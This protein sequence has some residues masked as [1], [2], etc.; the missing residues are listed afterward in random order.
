MQNRS[1]TQKKIVVSRRQFNRSTPPSNYHQ[2]A[3]HA[4]MVC[5]II[6]AIEDLYIR[7]KIAPCVGEVRRNRACAK[8]DL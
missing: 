3:K 4:N 5:L 6:G 1:T 2:L 8:G 7:D